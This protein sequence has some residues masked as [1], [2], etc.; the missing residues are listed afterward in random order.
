MQ[1]GS[2]MHPADFP[3]SFF[4]TG[5]DTNVGKTVVCAIMMAGLQGW[6]WKPVQC[7]LEEKTDAAMV[8]DLSGLPADRIFP[9]TFRLAA[10]L[11]PH[12]AAAREGIVIKLS[13]FS[14]PE[15]SGPLIVEGA[16]GVL[17]PLNDTDFMLDLMAILGLPVLLV[18]R[19]TL[20]TIN[21]TLLSVEAIRSRG[22]EICGVVL[23]GPINRDNR[24]AIEQYGKVRVLF[25]VEPLLQVT[26]AAVQA[27]ARQLWARRDE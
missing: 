15:C 24:Q 17:V 22:L 18:A 6:Y 13:D 10:P 11:S 26:P 19:S 16:G 2:L 21:H 8:L 27:I 23:G 14:L 7:G 1:V 12:A 3:N 4:V 20:G 9:E 25:E 5:S